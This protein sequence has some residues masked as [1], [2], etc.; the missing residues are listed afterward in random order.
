VI[1]RG[2]GGDLEIH[3]VLAG[4]A[5]NGGAP[6]VLGGRAGQGAGY[7]RRDLDGTGISRIRADPGLVG[8]SF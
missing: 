2:G 8:S 3:D 6:D 5:R 1:G 4:Q 7:Q